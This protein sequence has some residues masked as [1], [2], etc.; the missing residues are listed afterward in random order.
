MTTV[1]LHGLGQT[2]ACWDETIPLLSQDGDY[3]CPELSALLSGK[4]A[5][6]QNLYAGLEE[7]CR[8]I[9]AP[10]ALCGFSLGGVLALDYAQRHLEHIHRL[11]LIA[12]QY[13]MPRAL[14]A[15]QNLVFRFMPEEQFQGLGFGKRDFIT[16]C[17]TTGKQNLSKRLPDLTCPTL[18]L[19]G[20]GDKPNR[21]ASQGLAAGIPGSRLVLI[22]ASGHMVNTENPQF[23]AREL[24]SFL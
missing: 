18:V 8:M 22:P 12:A 6:Y 3:R 23:L 17:A 19:C 16:L 10:F 9:P 20:E 24:R 13:Q 5:T 4:E 7:Y 11:I 21:K 14:L 1:F 2:A 15:L